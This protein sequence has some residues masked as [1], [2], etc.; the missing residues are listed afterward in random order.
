MRVHI[1]FISKEPDEQ[2]WVSGLH[3]YGT[4]IKPTKRIVSDLSQV[5]PHPFLH[6]LA[7]HQLGGGGSR[8]YF[9]GLFLPKTLLEK[10]GGGGGGGGMQA[11]W[12]C[13]SVGG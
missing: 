5:P 12:N 10:W 11:V 1:F 13:G 8:L 7:F 3:P 2:G 9:K 6:I 4:D